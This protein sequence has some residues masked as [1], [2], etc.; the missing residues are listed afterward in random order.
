VDDFL[1]ALGLVL[2]I[3]GVL[4]GGVPNLAR[5]LAAEVLSTPEQTLRTA[6][7]VAAAIGVGIIW[8]VRTWRRRAA[9][10]RGAETTDFGPRRKPASIPERMGVT[11]VPVPP[12]TTPWLRFSLPA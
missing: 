1:V 7:L 11:S 2:V 6:G 5:R 10:F 9:R 8:L 4:Y 3:E 12:E